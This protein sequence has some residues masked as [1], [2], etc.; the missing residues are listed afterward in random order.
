M[1]SQLDVLI[2][3]SDKAFERQDYQSARTLLERIVAEAPTSAAAH[4]KLALA[5]WHL[6]DLEGAVAMLRLADQLQPN[7]LDIMLNLGRALRQSFR[8]DEALSVHLRMHY[9][10]PDDLEARVQFGLT[11]VEQGQPD[12][13]IADLEKLTIEHADRPD[14][15]VARAR[16]LVKLGRHT[17]AL[18]ILDKVLRDE[19]DNVIALVTQAEANWALIRSQQWGTAV[20]QAWKLDPKNPLV[21]FWMARLQE[22]ASEPKRQEQCLLQALQ[23]EPRMFTA[24]VE[25]G[26]LLQEQGNLDLAQAALEEAAFIAPT[27]GITAGVLAQFQMQTGRG[28]PDFAELERIANDLP[29]YRMGCFLGRAYAAILKDYDR[30]LPLLKRDVAAVPEDAAARFLLA[31]VHM[32]REEDELAAVEFE[33]IV[34]LVPDYSEAWEGLAVARENIGDLDGAKRATQAADRG[35]LRN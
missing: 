28:T 31:Q 11:V 19:P 14:F 12:K 29:Y 18:K 9:R 20:M 22:A 16:G 7:E 33:Q 6:E 4:F 2:A 30:A 32:F 23:I 3:E 10:Y 21:L 25:L 26:L 17:E 27:Y 1:T 8:L 15:W 34:S 35:A 24:R 13:A 5:R